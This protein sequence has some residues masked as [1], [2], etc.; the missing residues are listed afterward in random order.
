MQQAPL[1]SVRACPESVEVTYNV[2]HIGQLNLVE[3]P[4]NDYQ[5][6][7]GD[8]SGNSPGVSN[9]RIHDVNRN[10]GVAKESGGPGDDATTGTQF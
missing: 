7:I 3:V 8:L 5:L 4:L 2:E 9:R 6:S 1:V 10:H